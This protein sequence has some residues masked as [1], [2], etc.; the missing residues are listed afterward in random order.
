MVLDIVPDQGTS[1]V[2]GERFVL[3]ISGSVDDSGA[4]AENESVTLTTTAMGITPVPGTV[5][6]DA[7]GKA[8]ATVIVPYGTSLGVLGVPGDGDAVQVPLVGPTVVSL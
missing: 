2:G 3:D 5:T 1:V 7:R 6:L 4:R 8:T